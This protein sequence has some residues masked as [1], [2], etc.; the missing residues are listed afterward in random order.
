M[1]VKSEFSCCTC[2]FFS[3]MIFCLCWCRERGSWF[4]S[5]AG[6]ST[7]Y[8][9]FMEPSRTSWS[10]ITGEQQFRLSLISGSLV[11]SIH[12]LF[13]FVDDPYHRDLLQSV[14]EGW[15]WVS[16]AD[17]KLVHSGLHA[18]CHLPAQILSSLRQS[19]TGRP[20]ACSV[21]TI[22]IM[23]VFCNLWSLMLQIVSYFHSRKSCPRVEKMLDGLYKPI[24]WKSLFVRWQIYR[25]IKTRLF[26]FLFLFLLFCFSQVPNSEVRA[27]ATLLL[28]DA[29]PIH[30]PAQGSENIDVKIQKQLDTVMV[31][32]F[33]SLNSL[34]LSYYS[35]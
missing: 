25:H 23:I 1:W 6:M 32:I 4:S 9:S 34:I 10:F 21:Q 28:A 22:V 2:F 13:Q 17:G 16:G 19:A 18:V 35:Y 27:N 29:F 11:L 8:G 5:S 31:R 20:T 30:D 15:R 24:L 33:T 7:S 14:E 3:L 26:A 12:L